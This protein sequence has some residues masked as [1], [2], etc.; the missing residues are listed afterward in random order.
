MSE[1]TQL[2][3]SRATGSFPVGEKL[4]YSNH[5]TLPGPNRRQKSIKSLNIPCLSK[6]LQ[7][8]DY[9]DLFNCRLVCYFW[10]ECVDY[11]LVR[12]NHFTYGKALN[13]WGPGPRRNR[14][15]MALA[16][17]VYLNPGFA[18]SCDKCVALM[19]ESAPQTMLG[20]RSQDPQP[21][22]KGVEHERSPSMGRDIDEEPC[23]ETDSEHSFG[24]SS[25]GF[26]SSGSFGASP[27]SFSPVPPYIEIVDEQRCPD[28]QAM[29]KD[30]RRQIEE[31]EADE[32]EIEEDDRDYYQDYVDF[33][34][35]DLL[36]RF[37]AKMPRL[38]SLKFAQGMSQ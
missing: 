18:S 4:P 21:F 3:Y 5:S 19:S 14:R 20:P 24:P 33:I 12:R 15:R 10:K 34:N 9:K 26:G 22:G 29:L 1:V 6:I 35:M 27:M 30:L 8:L 2:L 16:T 25:S 38:Y 32:H 13:S 23:C 36:E 31:E 7:H 17:N 11:Q 37:L 28:C